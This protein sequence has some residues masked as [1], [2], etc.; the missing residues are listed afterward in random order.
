MHHA[1]RCTC[2]RTFVFHG[3]AG[4]CTQGLRVIYSYDLYSYDLYIYDLYSYVVYSYDP[5]SYGV[6]S[7]DLYSYGPMELC[8]DI[9][10]A[11]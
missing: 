6:Y 4:S 7:Y 3:A 11:R 9:V 2:H 1:P 8:P 10:M 5:Y